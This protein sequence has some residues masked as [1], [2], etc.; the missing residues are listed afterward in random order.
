MKKKIILIAGIISCAAIS[1]F[2]VSHSWKSNSVNSDLFALVKINDAS[3]E[4][5]LNW[6]N[7]RN[8]GKCNE[9]YDICYFTGVHDECDPAY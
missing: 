9:G 4:C 8:T 6:P 7:D 2:N 1:F 5:S 3:A